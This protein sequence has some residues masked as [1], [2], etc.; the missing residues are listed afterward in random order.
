MVRHQAQPVGVG[1]ADDRV[2]GVAQPCGALGHGLQHRLDVGRRARDDLEDLRGR[3]LLLARL[4]ELVDQTPSIRDGDRGARARVPGRRPCGGATP[5][6]APRQIRRG[7]CRDLRHVAQLR[8]AEAALRSL[9]IG[10]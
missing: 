9:D 8:R 7:Q 2:R 1:A 4:A 5:F 6:R 3:R 10:V